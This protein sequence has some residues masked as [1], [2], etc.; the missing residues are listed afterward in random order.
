[1]SVVTYKL[2]ELVDV[3]VLVWVDRGV[4]QR[5]EHVAEQLLK[6]CHHLVLTIHIAADITHTAS[7]QPQM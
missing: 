7:Y 2:E 3:E 5:L 4:E 1:V 6:A